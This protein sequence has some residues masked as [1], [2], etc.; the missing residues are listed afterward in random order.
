MFSFPVWVYYYKGLTVGDTR[1]YAKPQ[2][3]CHMDTRTDFGCTRNL[4][5]T[6]PN[7]SGCTRKSLKNNVSDDGLTA[8]GARDLCKRHSPAAGRTRLSCET[9]DF[10][11]VWGTRPQR[12]HGMDSRTDFVGS[13]NLC[14]TY[15]RTLLGASESEVKHS[16]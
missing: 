14:K 3:S 2:R 11:G 16:V 5:K 8:L 10:S 1:M 15:T 7:A 6:H 13:R 9:N 12:S 4:C